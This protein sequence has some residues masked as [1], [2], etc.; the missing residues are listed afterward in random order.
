MKPVLEHVRRKGKVPLFWDDMMRNWPVVE[1]QGASLCCCSMS[2]PLEGD[3][4]VWHVDLSHNSLTFDLSH[5][6]ITF[7][8]SQQHYS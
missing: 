3:S 2:T 5:N 4:V 6:S 7:D 1:L 8:L